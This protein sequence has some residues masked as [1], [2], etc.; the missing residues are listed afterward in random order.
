MRANASRELR[1][2][3]D[4]RAD[5]YDASRPRFAAQTVE[6]LLASANLRRGDW[7]VEVGAGTGQLT[8]GLLD[9]G[10]QVVAIEPGPTMAALLAGRF[11]NRPG[12]RM[13]NSLFEDFEGARE[14]FAAVVSAN[15]FHWVDPAVSYAKSARLL[16]P[17][18][19]LVLIWNFPVLANAV[20]QGRLNDQAFVGELAD[21]RREPHDY[22]H[23]IEP[24]LADGRVERAESGVFE[25]S[26][27]TL[28]TEHLVWS[29]D[30]YVGFLSSL[31]N[32]VAAADRINRR[33]RPVLA[34]VDRLDVDNHVYLEAARRFDRWP[35]GPTDHSSRG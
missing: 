10:L 29:V 6:H 32:G 24:R 16:R 5:R 19:H 26:T 20:L 35:R 3:F 11:G 31:A 9:A 1:L 34:G 30:D 12:F 17:A 21:L 27:W 4:D 33:V 22:L 2:A 25:Q 14:T 8:E 15:A 7:L 23:T 13:V 18:G 28:E